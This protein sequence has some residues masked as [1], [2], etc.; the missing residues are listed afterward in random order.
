MTQPHKHTAAKSVCR[1]ELSYRLLACTFGSVE[2]DSTSQARRIPPA[3]VPQTF[4]CLNVVPGQAKASAQ[5]DVAVGF[6]SETQTIH[7]I[8]SPKN[9]HHH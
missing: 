5:A 3:P 6:V 1:E 8:V 4:Q 2:S 7:A 9:L